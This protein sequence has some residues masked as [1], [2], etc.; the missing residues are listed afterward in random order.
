MDESLHTFNS[1]QFDLFDYYRTL[2]QDILRN[3]DSR[4]YDQ[5]VYVLLGLL[6]EDQ[7]F[8][9]TLFFKHGNEVVVEKN[10][11]RIQPSAGSPRAIQLGQEQVFW[12][13]Q[14]TSGLSE[15]DFQRIFHPDVQAR[16]GPIRHF[17]TYTSTDVALIAVYDHHT[18]DALDAQL[19]KNLTVYVQSLKLLSDQVRETEDAFLYTIKALARAAEANDEDTG[20]HILRVNEYA[21]LLAETLGLDPAFCH[22]IHYSAQMHDVGKIHVHPDI[23]R[24]PGPLTPTE[25]QLM[26]LHTETGARILGDEP[27]LQMAREIAYAHH[28][29]FDGSGYPRKLS[30]DAIPLAARIVAVGDVYDA[31]RQKRVYKPSLSHEEAHAILTRGDGRVDPAHFDPEVLRAFQSIHTRFDDIYEQ[32]KDQ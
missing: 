9:G 20:N 32:M 2:L 15:E 29:K 6:Q 17:A 25:I 22:T 31:L 4:H 28:E 27:R 1:L 7:S 30:G 10:R 8:R 12:A 13:N 26:K 18:V 11:F 23:L 14:E 19:L 16:I 3:P 5:P 24:K 21:R